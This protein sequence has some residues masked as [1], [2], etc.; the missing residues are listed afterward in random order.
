MA[1]TK[2]TA[3]KTTGRI[4]QRGRRPIVMSSTQSSMTGSSGFTPLHAA[5][6]GQQWDTAQLI[7]QIAAK[8]F[9]PHQLKDQAVFHLSNIK[10]HEDNSEDGSDSDNDDAEDEASEPDVFD[11][12]NIS[13]TVQCNVPPSALLTAQTMFLTA[14]QEPRQGNLLAKATWDDDLTIF[15]R[16]A[17]LYHA[18]DVPLDKTTLEVIMQADRPRILHEYIRRTG[19]GFSP[20]LVEEEKQDEDHLDGRKL[21]HGLSIHGTKRKDLARRHDPN[22]RTR[23]AFR[24]PPLVWT[25]VSHGA[26]N[27]LEYLAGT[28]VES[29]YRFYAANSFTKTAKEIGGIEDLSTLLPTQLGWDINEFGESPLMSAL[30]TC[31]ISDKATPLPLLEK[32]FSLAPQLMLSALNQTVYHTGHNSLLVAVQRKCG[33]QVAEFLLE[34]GASYTVRHQLRGWNILH[35]ACLYD[36][37]E[38]LNFFLRKLPAEAVNSLLLQRSKPTLNTPLHTAVKSR[39]GKCVAVLAAYGGPD[40]LARDIHGCTPLH[41]A[42]KAGYPHVVQPLLDHL[43][44]DALHAE[45]GFGETPLETATR[46][47][48]L[49]HTDIVNS[50]TPDRG[51][52][53]LLPQHCMRSPSKRSLPKLAE[54]SSMLEHL[55]AVGQLDAGD[56]L[57]TKITAYV[58]G[59]EATITASSAIASDGGSEKPAEVGR[60]DPVSTLQIVQAAVTTRPATRTLVHLQDV[61]QSVNEELRKV[62]AGRVEELDGDDPVVK[63]YLSSALYAKIPSWGCS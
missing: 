37:H 18:F 41:Y 14:N 51:P 34:K 42:V 30:S 29:A 52:P 36:A 25:A 1:R 27:I 56:E 61:L 49:F 38:L 15:T 55:L 33:V 60:F 21:Y 22:A 11:I 43:P 54:I 32:L 4:A 10:L 57:T 9:V 28:E 50:I 6:Y 13:S 3:R 12:A 23:S 45:N 8:Q 48:L 39:C 26:L 47:Q 7:L 5:V 58:S 2:A 40:L 31:D 46:Q 35:I 20:P 59:L 53:L 19:A 24:E 17:D 62:T 44:P 16:V 63:R